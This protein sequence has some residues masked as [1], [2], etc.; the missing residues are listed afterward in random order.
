M[1]YLGIDPGI[2]GA[3]ALVT[4]DGDARVKDMPIFKIEKKKKTK[5]GN[6]AFK[7]E[8]NAKGVIEILQPFHHHDLHIF[9]EDVGVMPGEGAVGAFSF[10]K[11]VGILHGIIAALGYPCTLVRPQT[12]KKVMIAGGAGQ[13][14]NAA[15]Y[16]CQQL[17]PSVDCSLVKHDGRAEAVLLA[18]YG[19]RVLMQK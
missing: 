14:K 10:G 5:K 19:R 2:S 8:I 13:D 15:R 3:I 17:F 12:W 18:E 16:R 7:R 6:V 9:L 4:E 11:G 1:I